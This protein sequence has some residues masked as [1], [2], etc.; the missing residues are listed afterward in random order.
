MKPKKISVKQPV[1][2]G[3]LVAL[4][5][6]SIF[7]SLGCGQGTIDKIEHDLLAQKS[8]CSGAFRCH[9]QDYYKQYYHSY[10]KQLAKDV[11]EFSVENTTWY[12]K[13]SADL[14][15]DHW[16]GR[17][18]YV[19][20]DDFD[21]DHK[22]YEDIVELFDIVF[23]T[24]EKRSVGDKDVRY[25]ADYFVAI[26]YKDIT[27]GYIIPLYYYPNVDI[28]YLYYDRYGNL[29]VECEWTFNNDYY[30]SNGK[31]AIDYQWKL[32]YDDQVI[33]YEGAVTK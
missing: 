15:V 16:D 7:V 30:D 21:P 1:P 5:A 20:W 10:I 4:I 32:I 6:L 3:S 17:T 25:L 18:K 11:I 13:G 23:E 22:D 29:V 26:L 27:V 19:D 33:E 9:D 28:H 24:I 14:E 8:L 2:R 12:L 31:L